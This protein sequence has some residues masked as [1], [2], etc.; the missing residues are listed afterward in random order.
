MA[1]GR[2]RK[3][4]KREPSGKLSRAGVPRMAFDAGTDQTRIKIAMYGTNGTDPIGRAWTHGLLGDDA[5]AI[6]DTA[7][8]IARA[9]WPML[10]VG[11]YRCTLADSAAG[12]WREQSEADKRREL[13]LADTLRRV[14]R[15]GI[16]T[17]RAFDG[18]VIDPNP[19]TGPAWLDSLIWHKLHKR[20]MPAQHMASLAKALDAITE[21]MR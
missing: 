19:D 15:M 3:T 5:D 11:S 6:R 9:Y 18:L 8:K 1:R 12:Y 7:R 21:I 2:K 14:D 10:E 4:A 17:R 13:W 16:A 20:D